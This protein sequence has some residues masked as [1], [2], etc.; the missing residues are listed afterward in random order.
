MQE[1]DMLTFAAEEDDI[2]K[3]IDVF[4]AENY[5]EL[6]RSGIKKII[7]AGGMLVNGR[8]SRQTTR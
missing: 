8:R 4:A 7:D 6:S 1:N 3:R 5:D 2:G